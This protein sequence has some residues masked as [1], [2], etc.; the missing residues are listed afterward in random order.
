MIGC[1][2]INLAEQSMKNL[3]RCFKEVEADYTKHPSCADLAM[4]LDLESAVI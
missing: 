1:S 2:L 3:P 4:I